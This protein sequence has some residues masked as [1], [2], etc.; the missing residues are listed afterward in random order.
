MP[1]TGDIKKVRYDLKHDEF[2]TQIAELE[3]QKSKFDAE[4]ANSLG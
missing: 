1:V 2:M 4:A 3:E